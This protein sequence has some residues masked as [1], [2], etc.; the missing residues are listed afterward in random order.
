MIYVVSFEFFAELDLIG[1]DAKDE[2]HG[3]VHVEGLVGKQTKHNVSLTK[4][5]LMT[6]SK[7]PRD[8]AVLGAYRSGECLFFIDQ[9]PLFPPLHSNLK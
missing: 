3:K 8:I 6:F 5:L 1:D 9:H 4:Y 7:A 2:E